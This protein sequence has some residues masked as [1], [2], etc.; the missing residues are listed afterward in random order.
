M[1]FLSELRAKRAEVIE[2]REVALARS[3]EIG[4]ELQELDRLANLAI[5]RQR[6]ADERAF[7]AMEKVEALD[8]A[9]SAFA[10]DEQEPPAESTG[11]PAENP[12]RQGDE[13]RAPPGER[14]SEQEA[15]ATMPVGSMW[16]VAALVREH[17]AAR[18]GRNFTARELTDILWGTTD[19]RENVSSSK[20]L[21]AAVRTALATTAAGGVVRRVDT[22]RGV[23]YQSNKITDSAA[24]A[25]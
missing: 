23:A 8:R 22:A 4:V 17:L 19:A 10:T 13:S 2:E 6:A 15:P 24:Q 14:Q 5:A 21:A 25:H 7:R 1:S 18:P 20:N 9:I 3:Q 11:A 12:E 16:S